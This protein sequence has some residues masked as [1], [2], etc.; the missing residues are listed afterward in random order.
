M[1]K[2]IGR[3]VK[4]GVA[5][6]GSRGVGAVP[7][8]VMPFAGLTLMPKVDEVM[9]DNAL[10]QIV[11]TEDRLIEEK[12][13]EGEIEAPIRDETFGYVLGA[14]AGAVPSTSGSG[15]EFVHAFSL[16][17]TNQHKS[18][19]FTVID[20]IQSEML[21]LAVLNSLEITAELGGLVKFTA[22]FISK[23]GVNT[24]ATGNPSLENLFTKKGVK[25]KIADDL[26]SLDAASVIELKSLSISINKNAERDSV[27]GSEEPIDVLNKQL[28]VEGSLNLTLESQTYRNYMLNNTKKAMR[29]DIEN[30]DVTLSSNTP[31]LRIELP[32]VSF[33]GYEPDRSLEDI[34]KQTITFKGHY[35][36]ENSQNIITTLSL[37]N[38]K[39]SY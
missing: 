24:T 13:A 18:L 22:G 2:V 17:N 7:A 3:R 12:Y 1:A 25:V 33:G 19:A 6:E 34:M 36:L 28:S 27:L 4:L 23:V 29:I 9:V 26:A 11:D 32:R 21:R 35:D 20:G 14:I 16:A 30:P 31:R 39:S 5:F 8:M 10:G 38:G 15:G 37:R